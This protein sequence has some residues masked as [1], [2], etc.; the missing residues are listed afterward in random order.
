MANR[1][2][3]RESER[4]RQFAADQAERDR[5]E[6]REQ[7]RA[8]AAQR[9][10]ETASSES[11]GDKAIARDIIMARI[12]KG[13]DV[14]QSL[15]DRAFGGGRRGPQTQLEKTR[16]ANARIKASGPAKAATNS[17]R[18]AQGRAL[19]AKQAQAKA[20]SGRKGSAR[21][22]TGTGEELFLNEGDLNR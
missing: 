1:V 14:P 16:A 20:L 2:D 11:Q 10:G 22:V 6:R 19:R 5:A 8:A 21:I 15:L 7:S 18:Q 9:A 12:A 3:R 13:G 4:N 17:R